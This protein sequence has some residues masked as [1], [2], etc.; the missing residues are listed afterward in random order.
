MGYNSEANVDEAAQESLLEE[1]LRVVKSQSFE[2]KRS[3]DRK[4]VMEGLRFASVM[5]GELRL[6]TLT[7]K[8]YYRLCKCA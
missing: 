2:M 1:T 7:P 5:L 8:F 6:T 4:E 3:L